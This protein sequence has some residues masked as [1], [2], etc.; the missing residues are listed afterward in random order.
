M[1]MRRRLLTH[2]LLRHWLGRLYE[3]MNPPSDMIGTFS[4]LNRTLLPDNQKAFQVVKLWVHELVYSLD[5]LPQT[6][7]L[8]RWM[9]GA[10][11][12]FAFDQ[13]EATYATQH[14][15]SMSTY[16]RPGQYLRNGGGYIL[17]DLLRFLEGKEPSSLA[18]GGLA[19]R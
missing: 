8:T 6:P 12:S 1:S 13:K 9:R 3:A 18:L 10:T 17:Q 16:A 5:F 14:S 19:L 4:N 7:F 11:L 2:L 15:R